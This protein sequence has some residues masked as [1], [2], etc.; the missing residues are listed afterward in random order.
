VSLVRQ[1][2]EA[3]TS[4]ESSAPRTI[5][6]FLLAMY[7]VL[8]TGSAGVVIALVSTGSSG[9]IPWVLAFA[10]TITIALS[11]AVLTI[12]WKDPTRL[13]LGQITGREYAAIR[14]ELTFGDDVSGEHRTQ[15]TEPRGLAQDLRSDVIELGPA[16]DEP[17]AM[18]TS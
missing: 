12:T 7:T 4:R 14:R 1:A 11:V 8:L 5:L 17:G 10:A 3:V 2:V 16:D 15:L 9:L 6:G 13:M 18:E